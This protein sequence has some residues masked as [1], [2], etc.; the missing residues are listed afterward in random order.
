MR[1]WVLGCETALEVV[2]LFGTI[3]NKLPWNGLQMDPFYVE[4][5][6]VVKNATVGF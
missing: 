6:F 3:E 4:F 5:C 1:P 2:L